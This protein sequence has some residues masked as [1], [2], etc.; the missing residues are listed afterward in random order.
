MAAWERG[1]NTEGDAHQLFQAR[2]S[3]FLH[4]NSQPGID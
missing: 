4:D 1:W 3:L 2:F